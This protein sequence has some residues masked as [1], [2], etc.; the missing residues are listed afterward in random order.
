M[1]YIPT[2]KKNF[3]QVVPPYVF[4]YVRFYLSARGY[5]WWSLVLNLNAKRYNSHDAARTN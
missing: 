4:A 2:L 5:L 1:K 3:F